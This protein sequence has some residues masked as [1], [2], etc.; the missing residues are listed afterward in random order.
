MTPR[1]L[2]RKVR[3]RVRKA[4]T[5]V[6]ALESLLEFENVSEVGSQ[7]EMNFD[8]FQDCDFFVMSEEESESQEPKEVD[9]VTEAKTETS[10]VASK[11]SLQSNNDESTED[12][13]DKET[14]ELNGDPKHKK[15]NKRSRPK[16]GTNPPS[17]RVPC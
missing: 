10:R 8:D 17:R 14:R 13:I 16:V 7:D 5:L 11:R 1:K 2:Q 6:D 4:A 3:A 12:E 9:E 15:K